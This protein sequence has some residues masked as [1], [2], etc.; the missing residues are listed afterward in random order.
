MPRMTFVMAAVATLALV[1]SAGAAEPE[2]CKAVRF[3]DPGWTDVTSTTA[4]ASVILEALGYKPEVQM[5]SI[6]VTYA[7]MKNKDIDVYFGDWQP[8][9]KADRQPYLDDKSIEVVTKN[10]TGA[11]YTLAVPK[12]VAEAGV[13]DIAD[14]AKHSDRFGKKVYGIE[15]GNDGNRLITEM[16][17]SDKFGLDDWEVVESSEAGM[18]SSVARAING[19]DWVAFLGWAPHPMNSRFEIEYLSGG[20]AYFGP[21]YGGAEIFT[22]IRAGY[23]AECP[24]VAKFVTN[25]RFTL[26]MENEM[27]GAILDE[28][29][30]PKM[31]AT[32]W[33][34]KNPDV[35]GPWLEGVTTFEGGDAG[36]AVGSHIGM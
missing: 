13:K 12:Y 16:I 21:N 3:S 15:P 4:T 33:L 28:G 23:A 5:L 1:G 27:M 32:E 9:T 24:N 19:K 34:K 8:S 31:A 26:E 11:K 18:L 30:E 35:I 29:K 6:A 36:P 25:L 7:S 20:D 22:D 2:S 17:A 10:L 14:L